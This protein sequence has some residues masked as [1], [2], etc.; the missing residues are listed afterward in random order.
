MAENKQVHYFYVLYCNDGTLY[1]GYTNH[2][3][4]RIQAHN[5]GSGAKYTRPISR[6]PVKVIYAERFNDKRRAMSAEYHFK[7]LTRAK[8]IAYLKEQGQANIY[9]GQLVMINREGEGG[10]VDAKTT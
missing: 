10:I 5:E 6:R 3:T 4:K 1:A 9:S 8:K 7:K 2:L